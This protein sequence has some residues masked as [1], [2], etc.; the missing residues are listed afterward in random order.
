MA[1]N[2]ES[3]KNSITPYRKS[4]KKKGVRQR[5]GKK[6]AK[7]REQLNQL[8]IRCNRYQIICKGR[9]HAF[10]LFNWM[11]NDTDHGNEWL[12]RKDPGMAWNPGKTPEAKD[13]LYFTKLYALID[14]RKLWRRLNNIPGWLN[15]SDTEWHQVKMDYEQQAVNQPLPENTGSEWDS[16]QQHFPEEKPIKVLDTLPEPS[17][18]VWNDYLALFNVFQ[19]T[20]HFA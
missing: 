5:L 10:R 4:P 3:V 8:P 9:G 2:S 1:S 13:S 14:R 12:P 7:V 16:Y 15:R 17:G 19:S 6:L 20:G 18:S 11:R